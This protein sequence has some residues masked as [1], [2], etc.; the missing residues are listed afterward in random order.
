MTEKKAEKKAVEKESE[1][2]VK[3]AEKKPV[4]KEHAEK[5]PKKTEKKPAEKPKKEEK[6]PLKESV[7]TVPLR[8]AFDKPQLKMRRAAVRE[9]QKYLVKHTRKEPKVSEE[10]NRKIWE[11]S[12]PPRKIKIKIVEDEKL[13]TAE[14]P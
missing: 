12:K 10:V 2:H 3:K 6:K 4:K 1:K 14:M 9:L 8:K 5:K 11:K 7:H 13:A